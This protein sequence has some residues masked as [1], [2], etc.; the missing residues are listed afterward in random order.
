MGSRTPMKHENYPREADVGPGDEN[1]PPAEP[2]MTD[3]REDKMDH[4]PKHEETQGAATQRLFAALP[5]PI[6]AVDS[7]GKV[8]L[9]NEAI[10]EL[11][12]RPPAEVLGKKAWAGLYDKRKATAVEIAIASGEPAEE[13]ILVANKATSEQK[14]M[15]FKV[16][17]LLGEDGEA[18][19]AVGVL[20]DA[21]EGS[22]VRSFADEIVNM[23]RQHDLGDID[24]M[25]PEEKFEGT[26][27]VMAKGVNDMVK[28]HI[29]VKKKAMTCV[30]EFAKGNFEAELEKFPGKKAFVNENLELLRKSFRAVT[31]AAQNISRG[32]LADLEAFKKVGKRCENDE[33]YPS[34]LRMMETI[35]AMIGE[36]VA[37]ADAAK[38]G[39]LATRA[40]AAKFE[41]GFR[42]VVQG[43]NDTLE[44]VILPL[45]VAANYVERISKGDIPAKIT[46]SYNG[47]FNAIKNNLNQA[48][49][50]VNLLVAEAGLLS[51][52]AI[53]GK[54]STRADAAKHQ[55]DFRKVV[56]GVNETLDA[57]IAPL[58]V[59][60][61]YVERISKGDIPA[62]ISDSYN[63]D[64]NTI[65]N[66]L[67]QAIDA[68]NLLVAEAGLLSKAAIEG[69]LATRADAAKHQGDFRK[70]V[71]GVNETLDA[72]I[73]PLNVAANYVDRISKGDIPPKIT[74]SYNGDF[75]TL[76]NNLNQ[77]IDAV[78]LLVADA[79]LLSK[80]AVEGKLATRA[81]AAKHQGDF[82]K[83][84][85]GVNE[86]LDAVITPLNVAANYVDRIS[87]GDIPMKITDTYNG[88][89]NTIKNNLN[90][91]IEAVNLLVADA[92]LLSKAAVAGKLATRADAAKHMGD[93]RKIVQGVNETLDAVITPLNVAAN[94]VDRISKGDIPTK[95]T[96]TYNGDF[97]TIKNNL[98]QAIEA[99]NLLVVDA[100][101]LSKAAVEGKLATRADAAK[102]QG[103]FRKVVQGVNETLDAVIT[104]LNVAANYVDRISKGDIPTK[105]TDTYNGDFNSIKNNLNQA[106]EAV[107]LLVADA[108]LLSKAAVE[109]KL[110]TRAE[111]AKHQG[112]FRKVV[113]GVNETLD[114]VITP[115]NV[116]ATYVDRI[117]KGDI[118]AKIADSYSGDFNTIKNNL[119]QAIDAVTLLVADSVM[120]AKAAVEGKLQTRADASKHNGDYRKIVEGV[121]STLDAVLKPVEEAAKALEALADSDMRVRM[122]GNYLGDHAQIKDSVNRMANSLH[123]AL[124]QVAEATDQVSS[125]S[126][127][128]AASSQSVS[129]GA[130]EQASSLEETSSTLEEM[131]SMTKQNADNT[132]QAK[133]LA[134][135][136]KAAADSGNIAMSKMMSSM[137]KI[138]DAAEGTAAIIADINEIAFQT[139]LLA[140]NA[141]VEAARA[142]DAGR[143]FAVVAEEV[144]NLALR[145]KEAAK[146]TDELIKQSVKLAGEGE[147]ITNEVNGNLTEIVASVAKVTE[148][149]SEIAVASQEQARG[150]EQVNKAVSQ[151]EQVVQQSAANSE[152]TSSAAEELASQAQGLAGMVGNF[153]LNRTSTRVAA[154]AQPSR[155]MPGFDAGSKKKLGNGRNRPVRPEDIIPLET[156]SDFRD[157]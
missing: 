5:V 24:I 82:R 34:F 150:I 62:K 6:L 131:S 56:Q 49:D 103:D 127:Q 156:D 123:D 78:N 142:G 30:A 29:N 36:A 116:A 18:T 38:A 35:D 68:V 48:I 108:G 118:P 45:N 72:V 128:I 63:G 113:Q 130:T 139:N 132:Q 147:T 26:Y 13:K 23:S 107:N 149:V 58:N 119:N 81:E 15:L 145:S 8:T 157:F 44:A 54:L 41:G 65:K 98:N 46:D 66:N 144:R 97:N 122:K 50:A 16:S 102:H 136:T 11:T 64:F 86:T 73:T 61:T 19:G 31:A 1:E 37:L 57:V 114:A 94:Y 27:R 25:M 115:L 100:G 52:A 39:R 92:G 152:E 85:Q 138:R 10:Q 109:G 126:A 133:A 140:L 84:V 88:D 134:Q 155:G 42:Q 70:V 141:A 137:R 43:V 96:D 124:A 47:D 121:N 3:Q 104:P 20:V 106:I 154:K 99:V 17:P 89:F 9:W 21:G 125:A 77:A 120:L 51:K 111:A 28:G 151:M 91:A 33:L 76:K 7:Q 75:N 12:G 53:E 148:I 153:Q 110:A 90:Q 87:K 40:N 135:A 117:S 80:A 69:K 95:I 74:A 93:F 143:G 79:G 105:I 4:S 22:Q 101:L 2:G 32:D 129:Q 60:A 59:A 14:E 71:Q 112:D 67:N 55:G 83:V 146:K